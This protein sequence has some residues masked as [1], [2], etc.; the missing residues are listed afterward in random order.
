R[1]VAT[2]IWAPGAAV[3]VALT[4]A[5]YAAAAPAGLCVSAA[6]TLVHAWRRRVRT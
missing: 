2:W 3:A 4:V 5:G 1:P 6:G